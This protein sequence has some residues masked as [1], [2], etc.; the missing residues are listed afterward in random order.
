MNIAF[1]H[2]FNQIFR[3]ASDDTTL[4]IQI[5]PNQEF[6]A[7][8]SPKSINIYSCKFNHHLSKFSLTNDQVQKFGLFISTSWISNHKIAVLLSFGFIFIFSFHK[9]ILK[10]ETIIDS[11]PNSTRL[12]IT[13]YQKYIVC[14]DD[15]GFLTFFSTK[16]NKNKKEDKISIQIAEFSIKKIL[17][18]NDYGVVLS[19]GGSVYSFPIELNKLKKINSKFRFTLKNISQNQASSIA[20]SKKNIVAIFETT[21]SILITEC[22]HDTTLKLKARSA[23]KALVTFADEFTLLIMYSNGFLT[24][25]NYVMRVNHTFKYI[26]LLNCNC[27][28]AYNKFIFASCDAG[29]FVL[30]I[31]SLY[32]S[33][34]PLLINSSSVVEF[35]AV[36]KGAIPVKYSL[37]NIQSLENETIVSVATDENE[38]YI[39]VALDSRIVLIDRSTGNFIHNVKLNINAILLQF[40]GNVLCVIEKGPSHYLIKFICLQG[41][42]NITSSKDEKSSDIPSQ[43][44][45]SNE[46]SNN[47]EEKHT[48]NDPKISASSSMDINPIDNKNMKVFDPIVFYTIQK[49]PLSLASDSKSCA[50]IFENSISIYENFKFFQTIQ[51]DSTPVHCRICSN[52]RKIICL[53]QNRILILID[54]GK[55]VRISTI[56][57]ECSNFFFDPNFS[58]IFII[59]GINVKFCS[60]SNL[61]LIPFCECADYPIGIIS[62]CSALLFLPTNNFKVQ[63]NYFFDFSIVSQMQ[64]PNLAAQTIM[65]MREANFFANLL[66]QISVFALRERM[67]KNLVIFLSHF[68]QHIGFC[69]SSALRAV[70]SPERKGVFESLGSASTIFA[71]FAGLSVDSHRSGIVIFNEKHEVPES[72][73]KNAA[74][75]LPVVMEEE[76]PNIAFPATF[77][78]LKKLHYDLEYI[79]SLFRFLDPLVSPVEPLNDGKVSAVGMIMELKDYTELKRRLDETIDF[80]LFDLIAKFMPHL[81]IPFA[82]SAQVPI[83]SF[84]LKNR[85]IDSRSN[86]INI[87]EK[88]Y[89]LLTEMKTTKQELKSFAEE[90]LRGGWE[91]WPIALFLLS[92]ESSKA[93]RLLISHPNL[94]KALTNSQWMKL[95]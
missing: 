36:K 5:S 72:D 3:H 37:N 9:E 65:S 71:K 27:I 4:D 50:V 35:R 12:S 20:L 81:I 89:P 64:N 56:T 76:G 2:E 66:R 84:F 75:L 40:V 91:I 61:K 45:P 29:I 57:E 34:F 79:E 8:L 52:L 68:P 44:D 88:I 60:L 59:K 22:G 74:I 90:S 18:N 21:N 16:Q 86:L 38:Q 11:D 80:C 32:Y 39:A 19:A 31:Y 23:S 55:V 28:S 62:S 13:S 82:Y 14:G 47:A 85:N 49:Q 48:S 94:M 6:W 93:A 58:L 83:N 73:T 43:I 51:L 42:E 87:I 1:P 17:L 67:G 54:Y 78:I 25:W 77:Y 46:T 53:L 92:G 7:S 95:L 24:V 15:M 69:L 10:L 33:E 26:D 41:N 30:P 70:E 63:I